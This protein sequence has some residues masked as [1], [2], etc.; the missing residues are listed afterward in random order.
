MGTLASDLRYAA[1]LLLKTPAFTVVA[2]A[3]LALGIGANTAIFSVV[4]AA[5]INPLP[6]PQANQLV[7][8]SKTVQRD[9]LERR[10]YSYPDYLDIRDHAASFARLAAWS[11]EAFTLSSADGPARQIEGELASAGYFELLGVTPVAGRTFTTAEDEEHGAHP[12][13]II[14]YD[15]W[16]QLFGADR[17]ALGR[18]ILL[19][20]RAF[21]LVGVAPRAFRGLDDE[22]QVWIPFGMLTTSEPARFF[23]N[24][25]SRWHNVIA[26][27]KP[28]V[29]VQQANADVT[30]LARQEEQ[31]FP[32]S[33]AKY[34]ATVFSLEEETVGATRPLLLTL[35]G[36]VVF[37]L[38]IACVNLANLLLARASTRQRETAIRAALGADRRRLARQFLAEG[39]V[40]SA[41]GAVAGV[42]IAMWTVDGLVALA[43]ASLPSYVHPHIDASV[44]AFVVAIACGTGLV[45]GLLPAIQGSRADVNEVLKDSARGSSGGRERT[46]LRS[47]LV[48]A[49]VALSLLLLVGA[50][51]MVQSFLNR[52]RI[53][54][55]FHPETAATLRIALPG[56][57]GSDRVPDV[58]ATLRDRVAAIPGVQRAALSTDAPFSGDDSATIVSP[59]T[60]EI[61]T[62][63]HGIRVYRHA[64][65][66]GFFAA[67]G[68]PLVEG[69]DFDAR[70]RK[71]SPLVAIASRRFAAKAWP[72]QD[73]I[74]K[75]FVIG[76]GASTDWITLVGVAGDVRY[77]SLVVDASLNPE[78]PDLYFPL[79]QTP[80][81]LLSIVAA[82]AAGARPDALLPGIRQA[83]TGADRDIPTF[84]EGTIAALVAS[85]MAPF[86]LSATVMSLFGLVALTLAG[87]GVYGLI[88]YSVLQRR[89]EIG[90]RVALG[91]GRPEIYRMVLGDALRLTIA[92]LALGIVTALPA[93]RLI[94]TQLYGVTP[95]DP[96]T[97]AAIAALLLAV[98]MGA[99]LLPAAR[100]AHV[101]PI[102]ALRD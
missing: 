95:G 62:A 52:Q 79:A 91:A 102:V 19:N 96:G 64:V 1:R 13:A 35:M 78:D 50:G 88:N 23:S 55:G 33:N 22:T 60:G 32:D 36:A 30:A 14:S 44:L 99:T 69:R 16:Q 85:R 83:I 8:I 41:L 93:A 63:D 18:S 27:L 54:V 82:S 101:D 51:L 43:P 76:R 86:R 74:G 45:L 53:D 59:E 89:Q 90:V 65:T 84:E 80:E 10:P 77:R 31:A 70:D 37:V 67:L 3:T 20:D 42:L 68:A 58:I 29:T 28:G 25:S 4:N 92:G 94:R 98:G 48:V 97:Y 9:T 39:V 15:L 17:S 100:A 75:R 61:G 38:L 12:V 2:V 72:G 34:G 6:Y 46:R 40:L 26:R 71:G 57:I 5:L 24:R 7:V 21:T 81:R 66:P 56:K 87:I 47:A 49:E 11:S 73:P